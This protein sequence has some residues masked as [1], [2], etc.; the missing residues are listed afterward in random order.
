MVKNSKEIQSNCT[1]WTPICHNCNNYMKRK[2]KKIL[3]KK[4]RKIYYFVINNFTETVVYI[5]D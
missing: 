5:V 2:Q 3:R 1:D 4:P